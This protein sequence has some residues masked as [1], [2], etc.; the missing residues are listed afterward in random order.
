MA[1]GGTFSKYSHEFQT[2]TEGGE[3]T[4]YIC[5]KCDLA[6]NA[7]IKNETPACPDCGN[8]DFKEEKA[9][10]VGNIFKLGTRY[11]E[12]FDL[13]F[14]DA[15]G[16]EQPVIM[17]CYGIGPSRVLGAIVEVC[18]DEKGIIWPPEVAPFEAHLITLGKTKKEADALYEK[19]THKV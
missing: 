13:K 7:E 8:K 11:S 16:K 15:D 4:I 12:P 10:E 1:S 3:D 5:R 6:I 17:G 18:H 19:L 9:I 2:V 14:R